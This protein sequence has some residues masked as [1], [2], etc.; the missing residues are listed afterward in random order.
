MKRIIAIILTL[1]LSLSLCSCGKTIADD[2]CLSVYFFDVGQGDCSLLLFPDGVSVLID[3]GNQAD[4]RLIADYLKKGGIDTLDYLICTH[5]HEDHIGG[6][7]MVM[8]EF[9]VKNVILPNAVHTS[10]TFENMIEAIENSDAVSH[11]ALLFLIPD[12]R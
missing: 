2:S 5:P 9:D 4:G 7:A 6:A 1:I 3:A 12:S 11:Q 10:A 8:N